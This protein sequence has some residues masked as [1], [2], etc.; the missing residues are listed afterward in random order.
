VIKKYFSEENA[1]KII[2]EDFGESYK[3]KV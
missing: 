2:K 1:I 3:E